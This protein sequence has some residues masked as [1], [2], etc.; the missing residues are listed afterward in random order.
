MPQNKYEYKRI[1]SKT[2]FH[3]CLI[4]ECAHTIK[5]KPT[6]TKF[7]II[8]GCNLEYITHYTVTC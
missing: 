1:D 7:M 4:A 5:K 6:I 2:S 3:E 8:T